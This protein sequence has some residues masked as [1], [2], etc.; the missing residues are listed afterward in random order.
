M[1]LPMA[2]DLSYTTQTRTTKEIFCMD[3]E[4]GKEP[5]YYNL[6]LNMKV[7]CK[8]TKEMDG[9]KYERFWANNCKKGNAK[10]HQLI[11]DDYEMYYKGELE[12]G[13]PN[14]YDHQVFQDNSHYFGQFDKE[15]NCGIGSLIKADCQMF[16]GEW[17]KNKP[18]IEV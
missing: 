7:N 13:F 12:K 17:N 9:K 1:T 10:L 14:G 11:Q 15:V 8:Q 16:E 6:V 4:E 2:K 3:R 18:P 5:L